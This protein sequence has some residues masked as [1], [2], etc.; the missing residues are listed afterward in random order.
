MFFE[1]DRI[2]AMREMILAETLEAR[3]AALAKLLPY[4]RDDF[5]G[6]FRA[7]GGRPGTIRFLD[8][9]L[10]EFLPH[11]KEQQ[12]ELARKL[13]VPVARIHARV[14]GLHEF[15]PMLGFRGCRL[16][17]VYPEI[18]AMQARAIFEAAAIVQQEGTK[19]RPE[20]MIPLVGFKRELDLQIEVVHRTARD[21]QAE[22]K[23]KLNYLVG[24]M[25]EIPRGALTADEIAQSAQFFSFGTNDLTQTGL[26]MSRDDAGS[27]LGPYAELEIIA[28]N[29]FATIDQVGVGQLVEIGVRKGRSTRPDLKIGICGEHGGDP[30]SVQFFHRVGLDYVSCSPFRVPVARL[31]AAQAA[32]VDGARR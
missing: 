17:I 32:L 3:Q 2:D 18:S 12:E 16:G 21:V 20:I 14:E 27:F 10:H 7:L 6:I 15:N 24:T 25:I 23:V 29:P 31:A 30:A 4:Q 8:P 26:G 9:P 11:S 5:A 13:G 1:G 22:K 28:R 19:V